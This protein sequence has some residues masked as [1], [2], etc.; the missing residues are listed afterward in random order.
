MP[1]RSPLL[2]AKLSVSCGRT[3]RGRDELSAE[4]ARLEAKRLSAESLSKEA[5]MHDWYVTMYTLLSAY[6]HTTV[7]DLE[8]YQ[9]IDQN[10]RIVS[11]K[12]APRLDDTGE[13]GDTASHAALLG[14]AAVDSF[15][16]RGFKS[17]IDAYIAEIESHFGRSQAE[18]APY[19]TTA[20]SGRK[21][22]RD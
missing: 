11:L 12:Y 18:V 1:D 16:R 5:E 22:S 19:A 2:A 3:A 10:D 20:V 9:E 21:G 15:F 17:T 8:V 7:R 13:L 4:I 14:A 6:V